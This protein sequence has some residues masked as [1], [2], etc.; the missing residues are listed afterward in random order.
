M[1]RQQKKSTPTHTHKNTNHHTHTNTYTHKHTPTHTQTH[2]HKHTH[3]P[4]HTQTH[5]HLHT[6]THTHTHIYIYNERILIFLGL[7]ILSVLSSCRIDF[8]SVGVLLNNASIIN[9]FPST[10]CP[11][12]GNHQEVYVYIAKAI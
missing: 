6:H 10:F 9:W 12:F 2:T 11:I 7:H 3:T 4:T 5:T 8:I 1:K